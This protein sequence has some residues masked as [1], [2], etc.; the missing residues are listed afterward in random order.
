MIHQVPDTFRPTIRV[1]YP[2]DNKQ[3]FE[4]WFGSNTQAHEIP[5]GWTYLP[6]YWCSFQVNNDYGKGRKMAALQQFIDG[7]DRSKKYFTITQYDDGPLVDF[8]DLDITVFGS[9]GGRIDV[10][11]PLVCMPHPYTFEPRKRRYL[12]SFIG[13]ITHPLRQHMIDIINALPPDQRDRYYI[14]TDRH[15]IGAY[16][17]IM[18]ESVFALCPRGYGKTSFRICEALQYGA[19]PVYI[20]NGDDNFIFPFPDQ[21]EADSFIY[22]VSDSEFVLPRLHEILTEPFTESSVERWRD[23][24][25]QAYNDM[26][27]F[28]G[29]KNRILSWLKSI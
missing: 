12:A 23:I 24:G 26:Y 25:E 14:S 28:D 9:G 17:K 10:P 29:C 7:L 11:I 27:T 5:E 21:Y 4:E 13:S 15:S 3:I 18:D 20:S 16:C 2:P 19:I 1:E 22:P 8:K 6:V